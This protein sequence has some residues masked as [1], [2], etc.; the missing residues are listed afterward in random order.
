MADGGMSAVT[1]PKKHL[2]ERPEVWAAEFIDTWLGVC[3]REQLAE[4]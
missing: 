2:T 3:F 1:Y 4:V